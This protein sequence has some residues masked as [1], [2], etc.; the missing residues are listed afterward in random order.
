M[1]CLHLCLRP[2]FQMKRS[3]YILACVGLCTLG[4][5]GDDPPAP[6]AKPALDNSTGAPLQVEKAIVTLIE[7][8]EVPASEA[9]VLVQIAVSEG[10]LVQQ[11]TPLAQ[12]EDREVKL[13]ETKSRIEAEIAKEEAKI[14]A[15][16]RSGKKVYE[17]A[18]SELRRAEE[19]VQRFSKALPEAELDRLKLTAERA[20]FDVE[21][22]EHERRMAR[23]T[24]DL[25]A[26]EH[27]LAVY[28]VEKR[29]LLSPLPG[30]VVQLHRHPGEW[31][32]PGEKVI[33]ILRL[34]RL[35]VE[36]FVSHR[37]LEALGTIVGRPMQL[38]VTI[39]QK[40]QQFPGKIVFEHPEI[41]PVNGQVRVWAEVENRGLILRPGMHGQMAIA[42]GKMAEEQARAK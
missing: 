19:S 10:Q 13:A 39:G 2:L 35:R 18:A 33:R 7:Q 34:D 31:V 9:G 22:V 8:V 28:R 4:I 29:K 42:P 21:Q 6:G 11:G 20:A 25:K 24:Q 1:N 30:M 37:D 27:E 40:N 32:Q 12:I 36:A 5:A 23:L 17:V 26:S 14:D 41:N 3:L 38:T 16:V 15:K